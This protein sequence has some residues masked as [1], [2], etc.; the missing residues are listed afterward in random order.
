MTQIH[1]VKSSENI[2][3]HRCRHRIGSARANFLIEERS[4][5][6]H[7]TA[8][9]HEAKLLGIKDNSTSSGGR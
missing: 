7:T 5:C 1:P 3:V 9:A 6:H 4:G 2:G 8:I